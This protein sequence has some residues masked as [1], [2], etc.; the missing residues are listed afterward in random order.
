MNTK[1]AF[2]KLLARR[3]IGRLLGLSDQVIYNY[4]NRPQPV[5]KMEA[6]LKKAGA[7]KVREEVWQLE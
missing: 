4:R 5:E 7:K 1:D 2:K 6:I 3:G